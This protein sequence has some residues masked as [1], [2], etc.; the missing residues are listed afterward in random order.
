[1]LNTALNAGIGI[2]VALLGQGLTALIQHQEKV[3]QSAEDAA[4][5]YRESS[6]AVNDQATK[7]KE[8][9]A[10]L[11]EANGNEEATYN[12]KKQLYEMQ[13][14]LIAT[15]GDQAKGLDLVN[16]SLETQLGLI[17]GLSKADADKLLTRSGDEIVDAERVNDIE[18][19]QLKEY[20]CNTL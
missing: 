17:D 9:K 13:Q 15:Y 19:D 20:N 5:A 16:G 8:L 3:R 18:K 12:I 4:N 2:I 1:M 10:A 14:N 11:E 6:M 7:Y